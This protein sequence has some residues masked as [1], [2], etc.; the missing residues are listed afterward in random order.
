M[1]TTFRAFMVVS[2]AFVAATPAAHAYEFIEHA[3]A[4]KIALHSGL[5]PEW[6]GAR[7]EALRW[8]NAHAIEARLGPALGQGTLELHDITGIAGDVVPDPSSLVL[9]LHNDRAPGWFTWLTNWGRSP[10]ALTHKCDELPTGVTSFSSS[11]TQDFRARIYRPI[12]VDKDGT[13]TEQFSG[14]IGHMQSTT[15]TL[16]GLAAANCSHFE[17]DGVTPAVVREFDDRAVDAAFH[18]V[19]VAGRAWP[20]AAREGAVAYYLELHGLALLLMEAASATADPREKDRLRSFALV[21]EIFALHYLQDLYAPGHRLS[22]KNATNPLVRRPEH[23]KF[24]KIS[25]KVAPVRNRDDGFCDVVRRANAAANPQPF[26]L[27]ASTCGQA[28]DAPQP[29]PVMKGDGFL[30][31][32]RAVDEQQRLQVVAAASLR[33]LQEVINFQPAPDAARQK[34]VRLFVSQWGNT[35]DAVF[36]KEIANNFRDDDEAARQFV[37]MNELWQTGILDKGEHPKLQYLKALDDVVLLNGPVSKKLF[38]ALPAP[39]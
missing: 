16:L 32:N 22:N 30:V 5:P 9:F 10:G 8:L 13:C 35:L 36:G 33:S 26:H 2:M 38:Q 12:K 6:S 37:T 21:E 4:T 15:G 25:E 19:Y 34:A 23:N 27:L 1:K 20:T 17:I 28:D 7:T 18:Q 24:N 29:M 14:D 11:S 39:R 31:C 3:E